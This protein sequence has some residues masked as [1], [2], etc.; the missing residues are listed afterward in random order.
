MANQTDICNLGLIK[1]GQKTIS[2]IDQDS[3]TATKLKTIYN[4]VLDE[5]LTAGPQEGWK[6][7]IK[8]ATIS[9]DA[10][11]PDSQY[12]YRFKLPDGLLRVVSVHTEGIPYPDWTREGQY[13][14]SNLVSDEINL[15]YV[16]R[17]TVTGL[18]PPHFVKVLYTML[19]YQLAFNVV[20]NRQLTQQLYQELKLD[21][22]PKAIALDERDQYVE[23]GNNAWIDIGRSTAGF[24]DRRNTT[25]T[26]VDYYETT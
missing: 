11:T 16:D 9:V 7:A 25:S 19:A 5:A 14:L 15:T 2:S 3:P 24:H 10:T 4:Q 18:F 1:I 21:V 8:R 6:F 23:E 22:M 26:N 17:V 20:Q 13:I 12:E